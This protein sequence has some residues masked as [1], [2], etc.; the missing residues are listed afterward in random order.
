MKK[1]KK[2]LAL[3]LGFSMIMS[4]MTFTVSAAGIPA[5]QAEDGV[6]TKDTIWEDGTLLL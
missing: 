1:L 4:T 3:V 2:I 6:V 5:E